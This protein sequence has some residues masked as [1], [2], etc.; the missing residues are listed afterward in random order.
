M[1]RLIWG[2]LTIMM[3]VMAGCGSGSFFISIGTFSPPS[4]TSSQFSQDRVNRF[5]DG[6]IDFFDPDG[7]LDT[8]TVT[9]INSRGSIVY[10]KI[11]FVNLAGVV[12]GTIPFFIDYITFPPD[13]YTLTIYLIDLFGHFSNQVVI[14]FS[15]P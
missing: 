3:L 15:V 5:I 13:V 11:T 14:T 8:M 10:Q 4:I 1:K 9:V 7:D 6:S 2:T 12:T